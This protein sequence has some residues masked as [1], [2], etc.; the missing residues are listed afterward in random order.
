M[1]KKFIRID[2]YIVDNKPYFGELT[3]FPSGGYDYNIVPWADEYL[4]EKVKL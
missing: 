4:G 1:W 3:F 2:F